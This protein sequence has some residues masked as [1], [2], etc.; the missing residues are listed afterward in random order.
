MHKT[1][2]LSAVTAFVAVFAVAMA[3][4][5]VADNVRSDLETSLSGDTNSINLGTVAGGSAKSVPVLVYLQKTGSNNTT[6][7]I[8]VS[9]SGNLGATFS[10][11][12]ITDWDK[13]NGQTGTIS[14]T[15]PAAQATAQS[16]SV[17][18]TFSATPST[19]VNT[20]P[21]DVTI[22]FSVPAQ[23]TAVAPTVTPVVSGGIA[24]DGGWFTGGTVNLTWTIT[25]NPTPTVDAGADCGAKTVSTDGVHTFT[26]AVR[27]S[28]GSASDTATSQYDSTRP[29]VAVTGVAHGASYTLGS[30]PEA[31]CDTSDA[32]SGVASPAT[33][34]VS[35]GPVGSV[36]A[37]CSGATDNAGN[38][39]AAVNATYNVRYA[40]GGW[41]A[42]VSAL[43]VRNTVKAGRAIPINFSLGGDQGMSIFNGSGPRVSSFACTAAPT[44]PVDDTMTAGSSSLQYDA[45][46]ATYTYVWK[47]E[48]KWANSCMR[49]ALNLK[50]G[51]THHIDFQFTK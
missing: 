7:P 23:A 41:Q 5:A 9:G 20:D 31:G 2:K 25:G 44:D 24:G 40:F 43:P 1:R 26:C 28:A 8:Q 39:A 49:L 45:S 10:G 47:S 19:N 22:N 18:V 32:T 37:T 33:V 14:F 46:T 30:V 35:G 6:L 21:A 51:S 3:G 34:S 48:T 13:A 29:A 36:T 27:N 42:P 17:V 11:V 15:A 12:T 16:Y 4:M 38:Q 50:D